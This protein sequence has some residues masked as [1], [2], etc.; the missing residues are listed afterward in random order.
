V[1]KPTASEPPAPPPPLEAIPTTK[2]KRDVERQK[3]RGKDMAKLQALIELLCHHRP[4]EPRHRDH[5]LAGEWEGYR[6]CHVEPD[7]CNRASAADFSRISVL[8]NINS[9]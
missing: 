7:G 2:F 4:L 9:A 8:F 3:K 6:D 5:P 1:A